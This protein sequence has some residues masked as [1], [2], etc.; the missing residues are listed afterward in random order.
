MN[1]SLSS[2]YQ[3]D[4]NKDFV[5]GFSYGAEMCYHSANCQTT[6]MVAA[7][8][9]L[10][11]G[12]WDYINNGWSVIFYSFEYYFCICSKWKKWQWI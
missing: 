5:I 7:I 8:A 10:A 4:L 6:N 2:T 9:P 1:N 3:F 12:M 11:G